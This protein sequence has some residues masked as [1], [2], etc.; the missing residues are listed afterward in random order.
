MTKIDEFLLETS[1]IIIDS[2]PNMYIYI[3]IKVEARFVLFTEN[4]LYLTFS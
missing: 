2:K 4:L 3:Y 1:E